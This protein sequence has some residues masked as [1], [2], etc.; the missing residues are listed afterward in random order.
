MKKI[1]LAV[2]ILLSFKSLAQPL[3]Y[4]FGRKI[5]INPG[6]VAGNS[7]LANFPVL[8]QLSDNSLRAT[9][10]GGNVQ[11][12]NGYDIFFTEADCST[13]LDYEIE[14]Y[15]AATG[16]LTAW[17]KIPVLSHADSTTIH[18]FYG[19][20]SVSTN[21]S[22]TDVW[23]NGFVGVWHMS[24]NPSVSAP[25][26]Q[27]STANNFDG[28][29]EGFMTSG[30]LVSSKIGEGIDFDGIND[31]I[32]VQDNSIL[33]IGT[34]AVTLSAW[35]RIDD[36]S[37]GNAKEIINKKLGGSF[38]NGYAVRTRG[39]NIEIAYK[40]SGQANTNVV[41]GSL[42]TS[43]PALSWTYVVAVF[44]EVAETATIYLNGVAGPPVGINAGGSLSNSV[45]SQNW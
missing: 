18:M 6:Q 7:P 16:Q 13:S 24:E 34:G 25:Q 20:P 41:L 21:P 23:Q 29:S 27:E 35:I 39:D 15:N 44:D 12:I 40:T 8:I 10:N 26:I 5:I 32:R 33:D 36:N 9:A 22:S 31:G 37:S 3:G 38:T 14:N 19:N 4:Q 43:I 45:E 2:L 30:D 28:T 17:V 42:P 11:N 1:L